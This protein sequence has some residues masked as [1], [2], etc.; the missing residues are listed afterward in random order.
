MGHCRSVLKFSIQIDS[1]LLRA[2]WWTVNHLGI[3][4]HQCRKSAFRATSRKALGISPPARDWP[5]GRHHSPCL[6]TRRRLA[7]GHFLRLIRT[8]IGAGRRFDACRAGHFCALFC[9]KDNS[10]IKFTPAKPYELQGLDEDHSRQPLVKP[11]DWLNHPLQ[12]RT[13]HG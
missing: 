7:K 4:K 5:F 3:G 6:T 11:R 12:Q 2:L 10:H 9:S 13:C 1:A 8:L